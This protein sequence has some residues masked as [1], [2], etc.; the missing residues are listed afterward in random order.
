MAIP[1]FT[2]DMNIIAGLSDHPNTDDGLSAAQLKAKFDEG[3][4]LLKSY[5][6]NSLIPNALARPGLTGIMKS[7][8]GTTLV[9]AT[10]NVDYA[11]ATHASRHATGGADEITPS[12]IGAAT[13]SDVAAATSA[14]YT[15][16]AAAASWEDNEIEVTF[17]DILSTDKIVVSPAPSSFMDWRDNGVYCSAQTTGSITLTCEETPTNDITVQVLVVR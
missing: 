15:G 8:N 7:T 5:I 14:A 16:T 1:Q 12:D 17:A 6:N 4:N 10:E 9:T 2:N 3:G 11:A 13:P